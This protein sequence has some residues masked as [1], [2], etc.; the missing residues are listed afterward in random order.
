MDDEQFREFLRFFGS[1]WEGYRR[2]RR[3]VKKRLRV[4]MLALG[5]R[6]VE[7]YLNR[8]EQDAQER[9]KS[10]ELMA[11]SISRF[12]RDCELWE[13]LEREMLPNLI[14]REQERIKVWSAGCACGEE[15][16]SLKIL[17]QVMRGRFSPLPELELWAT[18]ANPHFLQRAR[19]GVY[20]SSSLRELRDELRSAWFEPEARRNRF[21]VSGFLKE[22]IIWRVHD[23]ISEEPP[24][25]GYHIAFLRN[26]LLTYYEKEVQIPALS[27]VVSSLRAGGILIIGD[28]ERIPLE[29][30]PCIPLPVHPH[31]YQKV[32]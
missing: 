25:T 30:F 20:P 1:S 21:A 9:R 5:C 29:P 27:R 2:V 24:S 23:M 8:L 13:A 7:A 3:G 31:V 26:S 19:Q 12:F 28:R 10:A 11:V 18:D 32:E 17:W 14:R 6:T 16:Y 22:G 4:H 15:A